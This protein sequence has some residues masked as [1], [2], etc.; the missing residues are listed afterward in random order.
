MEPGDLN[1]S[2]ATYDVVVIGGSAA[3]LSGALALVRACRSVLVIDSGAARNAPSAHL[4]NFLGR[5]GTPPSDLY[6]A[7]RTEVAGYGGHFADGTVTAAF[8]DIDGNFQVETATG[9]RVRAR[10]LLVATGVTDELPAIEGLPGRW[11]K[12]V[13]HCPYCHGW[14]VRGQAIGILATDDAATAAH[15]AL[16]WRQWSDDVV[17]FQHTVQDPSKEQ[18]AQLDARGIVVVT[19]EVIAVE[20]AEDG[21]KAV[22]LASGKTIDR[23]VLVVRT[24]M[25]ARAGFLSGL[26]L[27]AAEQYLGDLLIGTAVP[28]DATGATAVPGVWAAG[29][30]TNLMAQVMLAA[31]SGSTAAA[32]INADLIADETRAAVE[33]GQ[34][35]ASA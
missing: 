28:A 32:A 17:V 5:D 6:S 21:L 30:V 31:A 7:G 13:L 23:Q 8:R 14:E 16:L 10:R 35:A 4:H 24:R 33:Y 18:R 2:D 25:A 9:L 20:A 19:G 22:L 26:G 27:E 11:G 29:N 3:G 15:Q 12:D 34:L 1:D